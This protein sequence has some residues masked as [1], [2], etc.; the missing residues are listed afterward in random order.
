M[1]FDW[2]GP[3]RVTEKTSELTYKI[4][5][6]AEG[7]NRDIAKVAIHVSRLKAYHE[8]PERFRIN[9]TQAVNAYEEDFEDVYWEDG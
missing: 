8:I 7:V 9:D 5:P 4:V 6:A 1:K 2:H 3:Y